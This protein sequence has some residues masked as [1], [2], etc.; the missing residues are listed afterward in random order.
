MN[1]Q[2]IRR[3]FEKK[4]KGKGLTE[5][6]LRQV[7]NT[8]S[9]YSQDA[10]DF[11]L[12]LLQRNDRAAVGKVIAR[13]L[14]A[15]DG[16]DMADGV[17]EVFAAAHVTGFPIPDSTLGWRWTLEACAYA[18]EHYDPTPVEEEEPVPVLA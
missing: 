14:S 5:E 2:Q 9:H 16:R 12:P 13:A 18:C 1:A 17:T 8:G 7:M 11:I 4:N 15:F 3:A 10:L 6:H